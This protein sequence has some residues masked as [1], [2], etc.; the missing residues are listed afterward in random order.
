[1]TDELVEVVARVIARAV[2]DAEYR[3]ATMAV[4]DGMTVERYKRGMESAVEA[5][6]TDHTAAA[7][8]ALSAINAS[9]THRVVPVV[10]T[11][12]MV[13]EGGDVI[14]PYLQGYGGAD[15]AARDA[16]SAMISA[17]TG[18]LDKPD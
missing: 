2:V 9:G 14:D 16:W 12:G 3:N 17:A 18:A 10:A 4:P 7:R 6:W 5:I 15:E 11:E 1:M 8:A 13:R